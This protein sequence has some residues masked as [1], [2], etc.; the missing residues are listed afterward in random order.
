MALA[1]SGAADENSIALFGDEGPTSE[2]ANK[3]LIDRRAGEVEV[4]EILCERQLRG[5]ELVFD[6][7]CLLLC[8][9]A[10]KRSPTIRGGSYWRL[11]PVPITSS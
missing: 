9:S 11:M 2:I 5:R 3:G 10:D 6:R 4:V 8:D 7:A 1:G